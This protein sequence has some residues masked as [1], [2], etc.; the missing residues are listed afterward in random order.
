MLWYKAWI[1]TR[2]RF[3]IG[4]AIVTCSTAATVFGY[5]RVLELVRR[6]PDVDL[7][8]TLGQKVQ[9]AAALAREYRGYVWS[10][11]FAQELSQLGT[12]FAVLLGAGGLLSQSG[13]TL[14][15]LSLP[16]SRQRLLAARAGAGLLQW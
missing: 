13:G 12:V 16:A 11:G 8:G 2:W 1:E 3:W 7:G 6:M 9:E 5:P 10:H 15:T 4:L 14:F